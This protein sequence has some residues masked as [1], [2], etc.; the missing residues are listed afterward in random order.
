MT[1][2]MTLLIFD[3]K[4][5]I[6]KNQNYLV[7][8]CCLSPTINYFKVSWKILEDAEHRVC[9]VWV[10]IYTAED[11]PNCSKNNTIIFKKRQNID[12]FGKICTFLINTWSWHGGARPN[13]TF[14]KLNHAISIIYLLCVHF[15]RQS[16]CVFLS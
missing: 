10:F 4:F 3:R 7:F 15:S 13:A 1:L 5:Y 9:F 11:F 16:A 8:P 6:L 2:F 12:L 14:L